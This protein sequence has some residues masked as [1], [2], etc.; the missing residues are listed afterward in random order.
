MTEYKEKEKG[1]YKGHGGRQEG[2]Q[3]TYRCC[4]GRKEGRHTETTEVRKGDNTHPR[5]HQ[6][7]KEGRP[8]WKTW[9]M[10]NME[11]RNEDSTHTDVVRKG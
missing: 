6:G 11:D 9:K 1:T 4:E 7:R 10:E 3:H 5:Y 2:G 8:P